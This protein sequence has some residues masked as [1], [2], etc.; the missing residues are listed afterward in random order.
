MSQCHFPVSC[1]FRFQKSYSG[2]ILGIERNKSPTS[3]F[4]RRS[5][6]S[7]GDKKT[8]TRGPTPPLDVSRRGRQGQVCHPVAPLRLL[9]GLR[10]GSG[11]IGSWPFVSSN[12]ENISLLGF[13]KP[14]TAE[15]CNLHCGILSIG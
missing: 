4:S 8:E 9:F 15:T 13:L 1:C 10:E 11:K 2:N 14:K 5:T 6:K 3:Y 12:S 7:K